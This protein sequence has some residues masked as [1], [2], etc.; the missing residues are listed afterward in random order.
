MDD[1][2]VLIQYDHRPGAETGEGAILNG[3]AV[4][5]LEAVVPEGGEGFDVFQAF[6]AAEPGGGRANLGKMVRAR[7][8]AASPLT[9]SALSMLAGKL[10]S[11]TMA[12]ASFLYV[13][14]E[15]A[16]ATSSLGAS[17]AL[18]S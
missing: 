3:N 1:L 5:L 14:N 4:V 10:C 8:E 9:S 7:E 13:R 16:I 2:V 11:K 6:G 18:H 12:L 15:V 17:L